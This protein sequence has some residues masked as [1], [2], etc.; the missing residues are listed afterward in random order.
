MAL[1]QLQPLCVHEELVEKDINDLAQ[2]CSD[3]ELH[4]PDLAKNWL[5]FQPL[6]VVQH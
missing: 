3:L 4:L 5:C 2:G 6:E 1:L